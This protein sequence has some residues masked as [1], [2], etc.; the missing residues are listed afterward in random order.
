MLV[1]Y[2]SVKK[3]ETPKSKIITL[4][5]QSLSFIKCQVF[6]SCA[7]KNYP[8]IKVL[9]VLKRKKIYFKLNI[10]FCFS[11]TWCFVVV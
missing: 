9:F 5:L 3:I 11:L 10:S 8:F 2:S 6:I 7:F 4:L 1:F